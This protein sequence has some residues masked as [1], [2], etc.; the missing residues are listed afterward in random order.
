VSKKDNRIARKAAKEQQRKGKQVRQ[1]QS[2]SV[3]KQAKILAAPAVAKKIKT[4]PL[5]LRS[6][7]FMSWGCDREDREGAWSWSVSRDWGD[8]LSSSYIYPFL[9]AYTNK[10]WG[11]IEAECT[12]RGKRNKAYPLGKLKQE[13]Q[14]R[15]VELELDDRD[16]IFRFRMT[17]LERLYGFIIDHV[18]NT[19]WFDP[20]HEIYQSNN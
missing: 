16:F 20:T 11:Q 4:T 1:F 10:T 13:A 12:T 2:L 9:Q 19:V 5:G 15:L 3:D 17:R 8:E 6:D 14:D 7:C 18:F